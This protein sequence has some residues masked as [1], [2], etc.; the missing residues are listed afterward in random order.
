MDLGVTA[1][2]TVLEE[3]L[4]RRLCHFQTF[5]S[6]ITQLQKLM[7]F[8]FKVIV[9]SPFFLFFVPEQL[10]MTVNSISSSNSNNGHGGGSKYSGLTHP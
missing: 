8:T 9:V 5:Q 4:R 1:I 10:N 2:S 6:S 7:I 3:S